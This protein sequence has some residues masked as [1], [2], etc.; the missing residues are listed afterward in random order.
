MKNLTVCLNANKIALH[1]EKTE[2]VIFKNQRKK[3]DTEIKIKLNRKRL[4]LLSLLDILVV[5]LTIDIA[6][7]LNR[8]NPV[9]FKIR[10][11]VNITISIT[12][13]LQYL[14]LIL[15]MQIWFGL[16]IQML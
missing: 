14:I 1:V 2:L 11:L 5:R 13:S 9:Q 7:K 8:A 12:I 3:L 16:R 15:I 10:N 6:V 4:T